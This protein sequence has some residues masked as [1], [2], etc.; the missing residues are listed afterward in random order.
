[1]T[2]YEKP[3]TMK[4]VKAT[5]HFADPDADVSVFERCLVRPEG[6]FLVVNDLTK[7]KPRIGHLIPAHAIDTVTCEEVE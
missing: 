2:E 5:I 6:G 4:A 7:K 3:T 1:M